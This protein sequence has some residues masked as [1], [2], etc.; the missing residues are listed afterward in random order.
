MKDIILSIAVI[1]GVG[2]SAALIDRAFMP[3]AG[4][5]AAMAIHKLMSPAAYPVR[6]FGG[7]ALTWL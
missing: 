1:L 2:I 3:G 4:Q 6:H 5:N 7:I